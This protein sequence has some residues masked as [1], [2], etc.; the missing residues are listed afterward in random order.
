[1]MPLK[2]FLSSFLILAV[3]MSAASAA[4]LLVDSFESGDLSKTNSAGFQ[5]L[6]PNKTSVVTSEAMDGSHTLRFLY[7]AT[8]Y[9]SEQRFDLGGAYKDIWF[10][11]WLKVPIN[12]S[13]S[14]QSPG[15]RKFFALWMDDYSSKG[16]GPTIAW[17]FWRDSEGSSVLAFHYSDGGYTTM[18]VHQQYT[19]FISVPAD[20]GRWMEV[21]LHVKASSSSSSNDGV[22]EMWRRWRNEAPSQRKLIHRTT[23][24]DLAIPSGGPNGW[25]AGYIMG[26]ANASYAE[27][28]QWLLD[29]FTVS[30]ESLLTDGSAASEGVPPEAP[31]LRL[32]Q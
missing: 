23:N 11:Y 16:N 17:E 10:Q 21:T 6:S 1:M 14:T 31:T 2:L 32:E 18:G 8:N 20:R 3:S 24:A 27:D 4:P 12:Y 5:W 29:V 22:I 13:H 15:N 7:P 25:A 28:T 9:M 19:P 26:W 30:T